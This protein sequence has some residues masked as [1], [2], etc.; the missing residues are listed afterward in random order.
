VEAK[1][2]EGG[3]YNLSA[4][5]VTDLISPVNLVALYF[6]TLELVEA[7]VKEGGRYN[8]SAFS[9]TNL[10]SPANLELIGTVHLIFTQTSLLQ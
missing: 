9:V 4:F 5:S 7:K 3:R 1:V 2:K 8:L 6:R 10:I